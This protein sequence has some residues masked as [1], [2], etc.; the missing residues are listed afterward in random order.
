MGSTF[1]TPR[2]FSTGPIERVDDRFDY[3]EERLIAFGEMGS[4]VVAVV[5]VW[6]GERRRP[7]SARTAAKAETQAFY[8]V[9]HGKQ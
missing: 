4:R 6:R 7:V 5:C 3:G 9:V 8:E 2:R 1:R